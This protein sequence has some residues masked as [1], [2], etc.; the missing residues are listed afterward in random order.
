[1]SL[2]LHAMDAYN[3]GVFTPDAAHSVLWAA[4]NGKIDNVGSR[5]GNNSVEVADHAFQ[6]HLTD[7]FKVFLRAAAAAGFIIMLLRMIYS[8]VKP[9]SEM[10]G[11]SIVQRL[12]GWGYIIG[13]AISLSL[14]ISPELFERI[15][16]LVIT[17]GVGALSVLSNLFP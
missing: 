2:A 13:S 10:A 6:M 14:V 4:G 12:G 8:M 17:G 11:G 7:Q 15:V 1:M 16:N 3:S 5:T 9:G